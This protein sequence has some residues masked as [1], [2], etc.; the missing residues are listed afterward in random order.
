MLWI[1]LQVPDK[2]VSDYAN[3]SFCV[4][5]DE[6]EEVSDLGEITLL[7][8]SS[9]VD[10]TCRPKTRAQVSFAL[11]RNVASAILH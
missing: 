4:Q 10:A 9:I 6:V 7:D 1:I 2:D 5:N 3:D 11:K 8:S